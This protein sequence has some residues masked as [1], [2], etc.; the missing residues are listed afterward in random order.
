LQ[1]AAVIEARFRPVQNAGNRRGR[2]NFGPLDRRTA[3]Q[4]GRYQRGSSRGGSRFAP[5]SS[6]SSTTGTA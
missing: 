4:A 6:S 5:S 2:G 1:S 3:R